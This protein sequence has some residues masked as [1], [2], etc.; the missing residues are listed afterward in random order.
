ML[1]FMVKSLQ[2]TA[3][4]KGNA[5]ELGYLQHPTTMMCRTSSLCNVLG[6][7]GQNR[8]LPPRNSAT[9]AYYLH[10]RSNARDEH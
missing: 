9:I 3:R 6:R 8:T 7:K 1:H 4:A 10:R 5:P 2:I